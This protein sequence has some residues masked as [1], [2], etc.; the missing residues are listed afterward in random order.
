MHRYRLSLIHAFLLN[1]KNL[2]CASRFCSSIL[3]PSKAI[4]LQILDCILTSSIFPF[5]KCFAQSHDS[6]QIAI[7]GHLGFVPQRNS[8]KAR[9]NLST[10]RME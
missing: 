4:L 5:R 7:D 9:T 3:I 1:V 10:M 8:G 6:V 2:E